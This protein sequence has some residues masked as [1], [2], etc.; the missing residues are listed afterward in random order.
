MDEQGPSCG[1][2]RSC[3]SLHGVARQEITSP[4]PSPPP[5]L[6]AWLADGRLGS[7]LPA[8]WVCLRQMGLCI[9]LLAPC[10]P[11]VRSAQVFLRST[12][13]VPGPLVRH[14]DFVSHAAFFPRDVGCGRATTL[15]PRLAILLDWTK[16]T[17]P[18][19]FCFCN[20]IF[21]L[22][23]ILWVHTENSGASVWPR[24]AHRYGL[25][26]WAGTELRLHRDF[27]LLLLISTW[28]R[29]WASCW[30]WFVQWLVRSDLKLYS[31]SC[32]NKVSFMELLFSPPILY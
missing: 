18:P 3:D 26:S 27:L 9:H 11:T 10:L 2:A 24:S 1:P 21:F 5:R 8:L 16:E 25:R 7:P 6:A 32:N 30:N 19:L 4:P 28:R 17:F 15:S 12:R 31:E 13:C 29:K 14:G 22:T 23:A 20:I